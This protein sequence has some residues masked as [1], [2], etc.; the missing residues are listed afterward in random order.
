VTLR[1]GDEEWIVR[2]G[3][4]GASG[5]GGGPRASLLLLLLAR[6]DDPDRLVG[7]V[8]VAARRLDELS[9]EQLVDAIARARPYREDGE[10]QEVFPDTRKRGSKGI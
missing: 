5:Q 8:L 4:L 3:G 9:D 6:A 1:A 2:E 10:R 7:E